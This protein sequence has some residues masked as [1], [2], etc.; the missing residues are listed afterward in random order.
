MNAEAVNILVSSET[1][2]PNQG[3]LSSERGQNNTKVSQEV[4]LSLSGIFTFLYMSVKRIT[5]ALDFQNPRVSKTI[6]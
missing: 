1:V 3:S 4:G 6:S 2:F 5:A